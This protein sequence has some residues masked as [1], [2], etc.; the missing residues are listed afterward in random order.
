MGSAVLLASCGSSD[1]E[2]SEGPTLITAPPDPAAQGRPDSAWAG[3]LTVREDCVVVVGPT[4]VS[5][6]VLPDGWMLVQHAETGEYGVQSDQEEALPLDT[7]YWGGGVALNHP[8]ELARFPE[9]EACAD[10]LGTDE[11]T[12]IYTVEPEPSSRETVP[13][14]ASTG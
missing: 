6:A 14:S 13:G 7:E 1:W 4:Y 12:L 10:K 5:V 11:G 9:A 2:P 8:G 3:V